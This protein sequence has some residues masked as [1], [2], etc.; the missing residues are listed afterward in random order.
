MINEEKW[1]SLCPLR[2]PQNDTYAIISKNHECQRFELFHVFGPLKL[3]EIFTRPYNLISWVLYLWHHTQWLKYRFI[4]P[5]LFIGAVFPLKL[6]NR[7]E[8][9]AF[10]FKNTKFKIQ[11]ITLKTTVIPHQE[12]INV[13]VLPT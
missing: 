3:P 7:G 12:N 10:R 8:Y 1:G 6:G 5:I 4:A 13:G 2:P 9:T 11:S